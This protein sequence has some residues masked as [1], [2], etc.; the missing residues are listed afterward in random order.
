MFSPY[1]KELDSAL[2]AGEPAIQWRSLRKSLITKDR[3]GKRNSGVYKV[4]GDRMSAKVVW[5]E[6]GRPAKRMRASQESELP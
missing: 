5:Y 6:S 2:Y 3:S 1:D 4:I